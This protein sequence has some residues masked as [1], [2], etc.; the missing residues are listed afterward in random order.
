MTEPTSSATDF[1]MPS[2]L[3]LDM[4]TIEKKIGKGMFSEV[5][6]AKCE[7]NGQ[8]VAPQ[9]NSGIRNGRSKSSIRHIVCTTQIDLLSKIRPVNVIRYYASFMDNN[10]LNIV[11]ELAEAGDMSRM[12]KHFKKNGRLIPERTIWKY[13]VQLVRALAHMHSKRIMHRDIKPANVFITSEGVVKLGDLG[14]GR[15]FSSK[16]TAAHSLVGTPYYMSPERIQESGYNFKSDLWSTG[17]LLYEMAALQS[18]FYGDKQ[19]L[20]SLCKKIE[21][22]EYPPLP[23]D[24]YSSQLRSLV[25]HCI[26]SDPS[27]RPE[28]KVLESLKDELLFQQYSETTSKNEFLF[29]ELIS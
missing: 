4:F 26:S 16:T 22:C 14:L 7:W 2:N 27:R 23:A 11:L 13:F 5:F 28:T 18:P 15:F 17:C 8:M 20:Y 1:V 12:I 6:R 24:I 29:I 25:S 3:T 19:N 10:Q 21:N 9:E